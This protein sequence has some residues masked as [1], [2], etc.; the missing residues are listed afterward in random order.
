MK[1]C[2]HKS[3]LSKICGG[4]TRSPYTVL[5][6]PEYWMDAVAR[7]GLDS[8]H[9]PLRM[10]RCRFTAYVNDTWPRCIILCDSQRLLLDCG[11]LERTAGLSG[12]MAATIRPVASEGWEA[13][14][15]AA[16]G[17]VFIRCDNERH[18]LVLTPLDPNGPRPQRF[19]PF[20]W[21][22]APR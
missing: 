17:F 6:A 9:G 20:G 15:D 10:V 12:A 5:A 14:S 3:E 8:R 7:V 16:Y 4:E 18:L 21:Q 1:D 22:M 2:S 11:R 13:E 19:S